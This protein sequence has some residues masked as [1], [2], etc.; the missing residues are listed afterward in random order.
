MSLQDHFLIDVFGHCWCV[1]QTTQIPVKLAPTSNL[2]WFLW[3]P[4]PHDKLQ[5][6]AERVNTDTNS[7]VR[8]QDWRPL[9]LPSS[10]AA[11]YVCHHVYSG[12]NAV[13][14]GIR[15]LYECTFEERHNVIWW[16][17]LNV[18]KTVW[19]LFVYL[20]KSLQVD[21]LR[22]GVIH[23]RVAGTNIKVSNNRE[24]CKRLR[25]LLEASFIIKMNVRMSSRGKSD[26]ST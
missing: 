19:K 4:W 1:I 5:W 2:V 16:E 25:Y 3:L 11:L 17:M 20:E 6:Q 23:L 10:S 8:S 21:L 26:C 22:F 12:N 15:S 18:K 14:G 24:P 7:C 9:L 13:G